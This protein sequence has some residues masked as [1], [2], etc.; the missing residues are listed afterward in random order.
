MRIGIDIGGTKI[1]AAIVDRGGMVTPVR[2]IPT[3]TQK[4]YD[5]VKEDIIRLVLKT[6]K[7]GGVSLDRIEQ[8]GIATAGQIEKGSQMILFSPNLNWHNA[9]LKDDME[10]TFGIATYVENDVNAA[11]YGEWKFGLKAIPRDVLGVFIG[12]G[13]GGGLIIDGKLYRG[14]SNVGAEVG[15][16]ILNPYGY[17]CNCG[18]NGCFEAYCGGSYVI[19]RVKHRIEEGYKGRIFDLIGG[20]TERLNTGLVEEA[21]M[22]G[23]DLCREIWQEVVEYFGAAMASLVNL[24]NPEIV[25]LGGGVIYGTK[26]LI[27]EMEAVLKKRALSASLA[28]LKIERASLGEEAAILGVAYINE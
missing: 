23:D 6:I 25:V 19:D 3:E 4:G 5:G 22:L 21:Y 2:R 13:I 18:N 20:N 12:T 26:H 24:L 9:P 16:T 11:T 27:T 7:E 28:G 8:V 14:S 10:K 17:R 1:A 15:H